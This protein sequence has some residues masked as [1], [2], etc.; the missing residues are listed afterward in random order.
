[1][2][3][4]LSVNG[5][6]KQLGGFGSAVTHVS[7]HTGDPSTTGANEVAGGS[8]AYARK[9][10]TWAAPSAGTISSSNAQVFDVPAATTIT[11]AGYWDAAT[12]GN[13]YGSRAITSESFTGQGTYTIATGDIDESTV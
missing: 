11:Y 6:N 13:F 12:S 4:G 2:A 7:L 3:A 8:P 5:R 9:S 1:M 10:V